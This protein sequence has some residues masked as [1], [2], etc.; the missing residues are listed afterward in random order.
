MNRQVAAGRLG[1][2]EH[3]VVG[4]VEHVGGHV[5][6]LADGRRMLIGPTVARRFVPEVDGPLLVGEAGPELVIL[7]A[8]H[9]GQIKAAPS[10]REIREWARANG[11]EVSDR[12]R[13]PPDI[14]AAY[15]ARKKVPDA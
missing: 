12:G 1:V 15:N 4:V 3:Q 2:P 13:I 11:Y 5:A 9:A 14:V 7:D 8:A 10:T 6:D